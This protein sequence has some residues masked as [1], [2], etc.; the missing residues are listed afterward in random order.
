MTHNAAMYPTS[1]IFEHGIHVVTLR[2][3][4]KALL[5]LLFFSRAEVFLAEDLISSVALCAQGFV[6]GNLYYKYFL[7]NFAVKNVLHIE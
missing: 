6:V 7:P 5:L 2:V 1:M 4:I 3:Q